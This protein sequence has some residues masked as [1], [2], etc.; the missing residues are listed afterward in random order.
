VFAVQLEEAVES[1]LIPSGRAFIEEVMRQSR[2]CASED[3]VIK[4]SDVVFLKNAKKSF[5]SWVMGLVKLKAED[6][7]NVYRSC[8]RDISRSEKSVS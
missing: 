7:G 1:K 8:V 5:L 2:K 3:V 4:A 6:I